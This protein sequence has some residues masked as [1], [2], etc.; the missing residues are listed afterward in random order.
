[1]APSSRNTSSGVAVLACIVAETP[2]DAISELE[3]GHVSVRRR[4]T[5]HGV[6]EL[7][8]YLV[9]GAHRDIPKTSS[10]VTSKSPISINAFAGFARAPG[11]MPGSQPICEV[12]VGVYRASAIGGM[13]WLP[14][15]CT[16]VIQLCPY[17]SVGPNAGSAKMAVARANNEIVLSSARLAL[18]PKTGESSPDD[19]AQDRMTCCR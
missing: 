18:M 17:V 7:E 10:L 9:G 11:L 15:V 6:G 2:A 3:V 16:G 1:M 13:V 4:G 12:C 14:G 8:A 5:R 19:E